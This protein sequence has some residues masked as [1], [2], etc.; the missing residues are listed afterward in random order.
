[1]TGKR[2]EAAFRDHFSTWYK[3]E[4]WRKKARH[5]LRIE[6]LCRYCKELGH[7][8]PATIADHVVPHAGDWHRF[9]FGDLQ[10]LCK[11]CHDKW[12]RIEEEQGYRPG[13][14]EDGCPLDPKH[15]AYAARS[16]SEQRKSNPDKKPKPKRPQQDPTPIKIDLWV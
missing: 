8:C 3:L 1:M 13:Y 5:Q 11:Q 16:P 9:W 10:S 15:P 12:K 2:H 7:I 6:P 14:G 4:R